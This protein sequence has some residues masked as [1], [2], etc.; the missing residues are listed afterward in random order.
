MEKMFTLPNYGYTIETGKYAR[1]A[2]GAVWLKQGDTV[3]LATVVES[4]SKEFPGFLPLTIDYREQFA[5]TGKIP[6]GYYKRE[7]KPS[8]K[9]VLT[10][11]FIDRAI[12]PLF[13]ENYFNQVQII[14]TAYS[15]DANH[16][17]QSLSLLAA[18]TALEISQVPFLGPVG[19]VEIGRIKGELIYNPTLDQR[20][21]SDIYL[22]VAGN[23]SG[24]CMV[25]GSM[26]ELPEQ[27][28]ID[29]LFKAHEEIKKQVVWQ[30]TIRAEI[31]KEKETVPE[32]SIWKTWSDRAFGYL[33]N[34]VVDQVFK[35]DKLARRQAFSDIKDDY[36]G[37]YATEVEESGGSL[38]I[39]EYIYEDVLKKRITER[40]FEKKERFDGR[41]FDEVRPISVE[42]DILPRAHGSSVF[43]R[44]S[45]QALT[46]ATLG[47]GHDE[48]RVDD[49]ISDAIEKSFFL[50]YNFLPFSTGETRPMRGV[51]RREVGHGH[52]AESAL[53]SMLPDKESFPYTIRVVTDIIESNGSSS[54]ATVCGGTM[55]LMSAGVPIKKMVSGVAMGLLFNSKDTSFQ[56]LTDIT[57]KEDAY[58]LMDF[59]VAGTKEGVTAIQ[60]DIKYKDG[61][62]RHVF[63]KALEQA[64]QGRLHILTEMQKVLSAPRSELSPYVPRVISLRIPKEKIGAVIGSGGK[65]IQEIIERTGTTIDIEEDGLVKIFARPEAKG[66]LAV[67]WVKIL[68]GMI[69]VGAKYPGVVKRIAEFGI[70]VE[71]APG[72]DGLVHISTIPRN[73]QQN[74]DQ[75][76][77]VNSSVSVKVL[78]HD[79]VTGRIRLKLVEE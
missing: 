58:G 1:Q 78:D 11:R 72:Q 14:V 45:T 62:P 60:M 24:I 76:Y 77:S 70:F 36:F 32:D 67:S 16:L 3:I 59:K 27:E 75:K 6:G 7:G 9:E 40:I 64:R 55:A 73:M 52:L 47:G 13:P 51:G 43:T 74:L 44:G 2:D 65:V 57:G 48:Q 29:I 8:D 23:E 50:H 35:P 12:R 41:N 54:M 20:K 37:T 22:I 79:A 49:V 46:T 56:A 10:G 30:K 39:A 33:N 69:E 18:S 34:D 19:V 31:G 42:V 21:Q 26:D 17:P 28:L 66:D 68:A 63:E 61:L 38:A 5:S 15:I 53:A 71:L 25:E 4:S